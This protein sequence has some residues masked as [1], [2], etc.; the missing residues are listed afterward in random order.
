MAS[1]AELVVALKAV[2]EAT[3]I[4]QE[5]Q[6]DIKGVG[7]TAKGTTGPLGKM[8]GALGD[9]GKAAAVGF[10]AVSTAALGAGVGLFKLGQSFD[11]AFDTIA[12]GTGATG[13]VLEGLKDTFKDTFT[14]VPT[15][16]GKAAQAIADLNTRTGATGEFLQGMS[17]RM[18]EMTRLTG[19]DLSRNIEGVT[20]LMGDWG[21]NVEDSLPAMDK[22]F[23]AAQAT[24]IGIDKLSQQMVQFG[25]PLRQMGFDFDTSAALLAKFEKEGVNAELV[26]GSMRVALGKMARDGIDA[27]QGLRETMAAIRDAGSASEANALALELF[28]AR[29]GPDMAAAIREGRFAVDD[30]IAAMGDSGGAIQNTAAATADFGEKWTL[31]KNQALVA[32]EPVAT[33]VLELSTEVMS[34]LLTEGVPRMRQFVAFWQTDMQPRIEAFVSWLR[35]RLVEAAAFFTETIIPAIQDLAA[36]AEVEFAK[37]REYYETDLKPAIDNIVTAAIWAVEQFK[38]HWPE[39]EKVV[40]PVMKAI[41]LVIETAVKT[42]A[43][44]LGII[45]DLLGGDFS[46]AW[47]KAKQIVIG[48]V[49]AMKDEML[50]FKDTLK[51]LAPLVKEGA[52]AIGG[53]IKD[54]IV[55]GLEAAGGLVADVHNALAA[56]LEGAVNYVIDQ[57]NDAVSFTIKNPLGPD[58]TVNP[59][60]IPRVSLPRMAQGG[61]VVA[62]DNPSGIEAIVPLERAH[63]FGFGGGGHV[64][65]TINALDARSVEEWLTR[66]GASLIRT[67]LER[68]VRFAA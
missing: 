11:D 41:A 43:L 35:P 22:L 52:L 24:G 53:A 67:A 49:T 27:E 37:F 63:E 6:G 50:L 59:P 19:G 9:L 25:A 5:V 56:L 55:E 4:L 38:K 12:I 28:G 17:M 64:T 34:T 31:F 48:V 47:D 8:G 46:G 18:L 10:A 29:A 2:N 30:L 54:G 1:R 61:V 33:K 68:E 65:I 3:K 16:M 58:V 14:S 40:E 36:R 21:I 45:V 57:V 32:L 60:D 15:D 13:D 62:G 66:E 20:R 26:M 7:E 23:V 51:G 44:S 42:I 39:I